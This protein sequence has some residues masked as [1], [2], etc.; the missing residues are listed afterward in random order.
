MSGLGWDVMAI[1]NA[2]H[3]LVNGGFRP[4]VVVLS[5][6]VR[7]TTIHR[8]RYVRSADVLGVIDDYNRWKPGDLGVTLL[9][10]S[11][12][13]VQDWSNASATGLP[14]FDFQSR[15]YSFSLQ[16]ASNPFCTAFFENKT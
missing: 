9:H 10:L 12:K 1:S 2:N 6:Y 11:L 8:E 4:E 5:I 16:D 13:P 7:I 14:I 3:C 15:A